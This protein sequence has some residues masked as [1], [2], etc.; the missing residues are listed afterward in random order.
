MLE[1]PFKFTLFVNKNIHMYL[2]LIH[3]Y[4]VISI[5]LMLIQDRKH[6]GTEVFLVFFGPYNDRILELKIK[7][8]NNW[9]PHILLALFQKS[10]NQLILFPC[11]V[12]W[13]KTMMQMMISLI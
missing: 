12:M 5:L 11:H 6:D 8:P 13:F 9:A 4:I 2:V 3:R 7:I 1:F 10:R